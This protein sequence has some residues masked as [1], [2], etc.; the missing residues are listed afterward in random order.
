M[1]YP[2]YTYG[3]EVLRNKAEDTNLNDPYLPVIISNMF[4][5]M[6]NAN[7]AGLAA[8]QVGISKKIIVVEEEISEGTVFKG[9]FINP[10]IRYYSDQLQSFSEGC[11]SLPGITATVKRFTSV[12]VEWYDENKEYHRE[13][14]T[15]IKSIILQH[16]IDHLNGI[17]FIDKLS[18]DERLKIFMQ[19]ENIKNK[20]IQTKYLIK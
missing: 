4:E 10:S 15:G 20:R 16:E 8:P 6:Y 17:L 9:V 3:E 13:I 14:F 12:D 11:L 19:L 2:I 18:L 5:T 7:G 1:F